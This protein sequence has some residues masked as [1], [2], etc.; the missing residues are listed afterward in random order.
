M[1]ARSLMV[2]GFDKN[3]AEKMPKIG[4]LE[5]ALPS[6]LESVVKPLIENRQER[7]Q[8]MRSP[9]E[10]VDKTVISQTPKAETDQSVDVLRLI[11]DLHA[12]LLA[13][14]RT[15]RALEMDL[16]SYQRTI[17]QLTQDNQ[18]LRSQLENQKKELQ[19]LKESQSE[20]IYLKEENEDALERIQ[21][22]QQELRETKEALARATKERSETL[23]R[24]Q[25]LES[26][27][28]QSELLQIKG[29]LKEREASHFYE[30]NQKLQLRLEEALAQNIDLEK[31]YE[32]LRKSFNEVRESLI[33][34]RD[35]CKTN[36]YS[37]S[38]A[39]E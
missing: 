11:E 9:G 30:E 33:L 32:I 28:E 20:S 12:Q 5:E 3:V 15:K 10:R 2:D 26:Q 17:H 14:G 24:I 36:F 6:D 7:I 25:D 18:D 34:L 38:E 37:L 22:L 27:L 39:S 31:K 1:K 16:H 29:K 13:S 23:S 35:S 4:K 19:K 21:R 8:E